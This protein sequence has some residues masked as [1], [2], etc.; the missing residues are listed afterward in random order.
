MYV[1][2]Y[3]GLY[4]LSDTD[5]TFTQHANKA[6][7]FM[8]EAQARCV[9]GYMSWTATDSVAYGDLEVERAYV[10]KR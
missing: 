1:I 3:H 4:L 9:A 2:R 5:R 8:Y 7:K 10:E 6:Q